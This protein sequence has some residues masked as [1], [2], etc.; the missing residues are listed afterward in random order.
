MAIQISGTQVVSNAGDLTNIRNIE[1][2]SGWTSQEIDS[3]SGT[4]VTP[5]FDAGN[6]GS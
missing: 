4:S 5:N 1:S 6:N 3:L 2:V